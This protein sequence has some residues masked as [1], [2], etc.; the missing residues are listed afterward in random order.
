ML[1]SQSIQACTPASPANRISDYPITINPSI[2]SIEEFPELS[3]NDDSTIHNQLSLSQLRNSEPGE[4]RSQRSSYDFL[5]PPRSS[6]YN[7]S[8]VVRCISPLPLHK[9]L[10]SEGNIIFEPVNTDDSN[11]F[12]P[13]EEELS[14]VDD[15]LQKKKNKN[16]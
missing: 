6:N 9:T 15:Y 10:N 3:A 13:C 16:E 14:K 2:S 11:L 5:N 1:N 4:D 7:P 12:C 8:K